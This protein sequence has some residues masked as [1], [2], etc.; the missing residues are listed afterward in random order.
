MFISNLKAYLISSDHYIYN[1]LH[2]ITCS[3][4]VRSIFTIHNANKL[5]SIPVT[6]LKEFKKY[7]SKKSRLKWGIFSYVKLGSG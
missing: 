3:S 2:T 1:Q 4:D 7:C 6:K 5:F